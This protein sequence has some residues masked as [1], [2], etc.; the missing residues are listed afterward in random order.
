MHSPM[1]TRSFVPSSDGTIHRLG[2]RRRRR[3]ADK[4][5]KLSASAKESRLCEIIARTA[6]G[7]G[8]VDRRRITGGRKVCPRNDTRTRNRTATKASAAALTDKIQSI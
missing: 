7:F 2:R 1:A 5:S 4:Q 8:G 6:I 3:D